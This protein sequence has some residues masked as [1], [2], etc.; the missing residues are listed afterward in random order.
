MGFG[1]RGRIFG[2][3]SFPLGWW[4]G[5]RGGE[6]PFGPTME[7]PLGFSYG[8]VKTFLPAVEDSIAVPVRS[9]KAL[10]VERHL[11]GRT[12]ETVEMEVKDR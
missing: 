7:L 8:Y 5:C 11:A 3:R 1:L 9:G 6:G 12:L 2:G 4:G 10:L